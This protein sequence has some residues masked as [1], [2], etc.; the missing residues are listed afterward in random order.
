MFKPKN[1]LISLAV[2]ALLAACGGGGGDDNPNAGGSSDGN[3]NGNPT[4]PGGQTFESTADAKL[5]SGFESNNQVLI[6][7]NSS[8][9][10]AKFASTDFSDNTARPATDPFPGSYGLYAQERTTNAPLKSFGYDFRLS[11]TSAAENGTGRVAFELKDQATA[12]QEVL[13][14]LVDKVN[15]TVAT[16]GAGFTPTVTIPADAKVY[17][18][19]QNAA[20][21]KASVNVAA[22]SDLVTVIPTPGSAV[23]GDYSIVLNVDKAV[24]AAAAGA[25][26]QDQTVLQGVK[27]F[28][29]TKTEP[30]AVT[31]SLSNVSMASVSATGSAPLV[32]ADLGVDNTKVAGIKDGAGY[33]GFL[34]VDEDSPEVTVAP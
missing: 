31:M 15:Y 10:Y 21:Q 8:T 12:Q 5:A 7:N 19:A 24:A 2:V 26:G 30:F 33:S 16:A 20:G 27:D 3:G 6:G 9:G 18:F 34:A 4:A 32:V 29:A 13:R 23:A 11:G 17:V 1:T 22:A 25:G 28:R 14:I